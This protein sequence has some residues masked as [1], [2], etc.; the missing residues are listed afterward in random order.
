[1]K[2]PTRF[3]VIGVGLWGE[4]HAEIYSNH[5]YAALAAVCD[6]DSKRAEQVAQAYGAERVYTDFRDLA[7]D[8]GI[9]AV[10]V[11]TP[12]FAHRDPIVAAAEA[13]KHIITEKPLAT[14][15]EDAEAIAKAVRIAGIT[16]MVDFHARWNPPLAIARQNIAEGKLGRI[17]S[18]YFRLNDTISVPTEMLSWAEKS[19]VLWFLG[20]H[21]VDS[22][23]FLF[24]DEVERVYSVSRSSVLK[25]RGVD[26]PDLY[27]SVLEFRSGIVATIENN[28]IIPNT[29]P[30][31]N[32]IKVN[33]LGSKGMINMDL[34]NNQMIERYLEDSTDHPDCLV[35]PQVRDRHVGFAYESIRD[36]VDCLF[37]GKEVQANLEDGLNVTKV[38]LAIMESASTGVPVTVRY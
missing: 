22:L 11:V 8:P 17:V 28:W 12:D 35:K 1:V 23:R 14:T 25:G 37:L 15:L 18:A 16:F 4:V 33:I 34:T 9:D 24:E 26:V 10:A 36:F 38:V 27:Q 21:T 20:S 32:D 19:S 5:P 30:S 31:V 2:D 7:A 29:H 3:G 6:R 13:G